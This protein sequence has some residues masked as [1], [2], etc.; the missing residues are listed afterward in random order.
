[1][2]VDTPFAISPSRWSYMATSDADR[3]SYLERELY[4]AGLLISSYERDLEKVRAE[5]AQERHWREQLSGDLVRC[6][7]DRLTANARL[8]Q[9]VGIE[10]RYEI[11]ADQ[12]D[13]YADHLARQATELLRLRS[14]L[15]ALEGYDNGNEPF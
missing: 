10:E 2:N 7:D 4:A 5:L 3:I 9:L 11:L 6:H 14:R 13:W 15:Q 1:M 12:I 8:A